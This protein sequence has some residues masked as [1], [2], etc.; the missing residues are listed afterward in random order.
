MSPQGILRQAEKNKIELIAITDHNVVDH[1][2]LIHKLGKK[3]KVNIILGVELTTKEE[4]HLMGY[5]PDEKSTREMEK[6]IAEC[7]PKM[8]NNA[9]F[10][11]YQ[12]IYND[13]EQIVKIDH[14]LRQNAL[15]IGL[16][17]LVRFIHFIG[18][19]SIPAHIDR[20]HCSIKSQIG[21]L[22]PES[23]FDAVEVSKFNWRNKKYEV[24][25]L[26]KGFPVISGSDSHFLEDFGTFF[27][28]IEDCNPITDFKSLKNYLRYIRIEK[29]S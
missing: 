2:I 28:E 6:K 27:I 9:S 13:K 3:S 1:S 22:D 7:L 26:L 20:D 25:N 21:F 8:E 19:I 5:F 15:Q 11:G 18:G 10:F 4:I 24:G 12:L 29:H 17:D 23:D 14:V 16:D